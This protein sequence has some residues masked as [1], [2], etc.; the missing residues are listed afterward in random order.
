MLGYFSKGWNTFA[1]IYFWLSEVCGAILTLTLWLIMLSF[2]EP[3]EV[4]FQPR[5]E[6]IALLKE[7]LTQMN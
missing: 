7:R 3:Y 4:E 2:P 1:R 6:A 5:S